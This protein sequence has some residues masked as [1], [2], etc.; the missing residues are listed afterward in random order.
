[1]HCYCFNELKTKPAEL[2]NIDFS[3]IKASDT[4]KYC[5]D[6]FVSYSYVMSLKYGSPMVIIGINMIVPMI[7][8]MFSKFERQKTLNEETMGTF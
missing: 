6:W 5:K 4:E 1:M 3:D 8:A 2:F 7:F